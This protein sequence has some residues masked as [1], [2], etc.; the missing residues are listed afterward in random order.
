M[1]EDRGY[2]DRFEIINRNRSFNE[3]SRQLIGI[4]PDGDIDTHVLYS[5]MKPSLMSLAFILFSLLITN[6][7][8]KFSCILRNISYELQR[9]SL[10]R[11][12]TKTRCKT[13]IRKKATQVVII[14]EISLEL[15]ILSLKLSH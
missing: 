14:I 10:I 4:N 11:Y 3:F 2:E 9:E 13:I 7:G 5:F 1:D 6:S 12:S 15:I 8:I